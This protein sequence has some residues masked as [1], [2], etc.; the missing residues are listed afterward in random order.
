MTEDQKAIS[1]I[2]DL[3]QSSKGVP[4][5]VPWI[6][7]EM[8]LAGRRCELPALLEQLSD[9]KLITSERDALR[10]RRY[11]ITPAGRD[12]LDNI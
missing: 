5:T 6:E 10:I 7:A 8:K 12:A 1:L 9:S 2:L 4:R 3:L 11:T